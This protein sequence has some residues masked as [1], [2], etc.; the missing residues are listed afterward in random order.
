MYTIKSYFGVL[1]TS[2]INCIC[3]NN[4]SNWKRDLNV[5]IWFWFAFYQEK[6][7]KSLNLI[8]GIFALLRDAHAS[9]EIHWIRYYTKWILWTWPWWKCTIGWCTCPKW[10]GIFPFN[11]F[12]WTT[13]WPI[14]NEK[15]TSLFHTHRIIENRTN[16]RIRWTNHAFST[17]L[18]FACGTLQSRATWKYLP[19]L[20]NVVEYTPDLQWNWETE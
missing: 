15:W 20:A 6:N 4:W 2:L 17:R 12:I 9:I 3:I 1:Y 11:K 7:S 16:W 8:A 10:I 18:H 13:L 19:H 5:L 14:S